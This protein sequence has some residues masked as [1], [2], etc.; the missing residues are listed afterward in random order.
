MSDSHQHISVLLEPS[1]EALSLVAGGCYVD[2][3]FGRGGH[4]RAV[5]AQLGEQGRVLGF[6]KDPQAIATGQALASEDARFAIVQRSFAEMADELAVRGLA[7]HV[8][9]VLLDLGVSSPQLDDASRGFS[10]LQDGPLDMRMNPD[11]GV[12]AAEWIA[13]ADE[14]EIAR[15]FYQYGEERFSRRMARA[16]VQRREQAPFTHT[17]DLAEVIKEANPAWEKGKHPATRAFQGLR[18]HVNQE[19]EDLERG[20]EAALDVLAVGGRLAVISF[21][22]LEDRIVKQFMR[23]QVKG[24]QDNLPRN[25]PV[26][27]EPFQPRLKLMGKALKASDAEV[28]ANPRARSAVLRIAEKLR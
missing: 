3:T 2:G 16:I 1:I 13:V 20:L 17:L 24:E 4:T 14:E 19:L 21:H 8:D 12:S 27:L 15:V 18:I 28:R 22:S 7:G 6:D 25:L 26:R 23:K 10:F 11:A 9:G 5:L